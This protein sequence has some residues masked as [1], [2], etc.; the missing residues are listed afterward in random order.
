MST[1]LGIAVILLAYGVFM[2]WLW[3]VIINDLGANPLRWKAERRA[4]RDRATA[5]RIGRLEHE[6]GYT[7]CSNEACR[8][9]NRDAGIDR[10]WMYRGSRALDG[11]L[12]AGLLSINDVRRMGGL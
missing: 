7:P 6:L 9:C 12:A 1:A 11:A 4:Q 2:A 8:E 5:S 10:L 3:G